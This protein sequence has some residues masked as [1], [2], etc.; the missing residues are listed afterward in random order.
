M[1]RACRIN[2]LSIIL[3]ISITDRC[4]PL[5]RTREA[6]SPAYAKQLLWFIYN[7]NNDYYDVQHRTA[8]SRMKMERSGV[9]CGVLCKRTQI[10]NTARRNIESNS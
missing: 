3:N 10:G 1:I 2:S 8:A 5:Y 7:Q 9:V 4:R 6:L